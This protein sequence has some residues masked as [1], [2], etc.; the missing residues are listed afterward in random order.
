MKLVDLV[1]VYDDALPLSVCQETISIFETD[2]A[3]QFQADSRKSWIEYII[4]NN[5]GADWRALEQQYLNTM[6]EYFKRYCEL[7]VAGMLKR[8]T[9][10]AFEHLK[11][12]KYCAGDNH[13]FELHIDAFDKRTAVR[14]V[15]FLFYLNDVSQGGETQFPNLNL[16]IDAKAGRLLILP[17]MWMY[18]HQ[19]MPP[20]SNHKYI[21]TSYL[22][23]CLVE[24]RYLFSYPLF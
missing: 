6:I 2:K 13:E 11:M 9:P 5:K 21:V 14:T 10:R 15:G 22:N 19:G 18:E 12:K 8:Q 17:P 1:Q 7:P 20:V 23:Y 4:T 16:S 24:D 3:G